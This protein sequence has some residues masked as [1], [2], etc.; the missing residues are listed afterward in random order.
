MTRTFT[1]CRT[2]STAKSGSRSYWPSA[3]RYSILT[4]WPSTNPVSFRPRRNATIKLVSAAGQPGKR[5]PTTDFA[6]CCARAESGH[7]A[8]APPRSVMNSRRFIGLPQCQGSQTKYSRSGPCTA[9][10]ATRFRP[11]WVKSPH[12]RTATWEF[13]LTLQQRSLAKDS[14]SLLRS[15]KKAAN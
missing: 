7:A 1:L 10:T 9:A 5:T 15:K 14:R 6:A 11:V 13:A 8:A 12:Y 3:K 4:F 2:R